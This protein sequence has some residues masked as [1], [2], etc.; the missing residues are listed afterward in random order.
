MR[1]KL[2]LRPIGLLYGAAADAAV[3][4]GVALPLAGGPIAFAAAEL[5]E[6]VARQRTATNLHRA[7]FGGHARRR[8][9]RTA[10]AGHR[11]AAALRRHRAR[12]PGADGHRQRHP[13]QFL[14]RR[15]LR[16]QGGGDRPCRRAG[17][18]RRGHRRYRRRVDAA[19]IGPCRGGAGG[20]ARAAGDRGAQGDQR[21]DLDRYAEGQRRP[22][23]GKS[24]RQD[25][26]RRLGA[27]L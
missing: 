18:S 15:A 13:G 27:D 5:I 20:H 8:S 10:R 2:Y 24:R 14:R 9:R 7:G 3:A 25:L 26:Q 4:A 16:Q 21:R 22:R 19:G 17:P 12:P 23:G 6:G 1:A 11:E